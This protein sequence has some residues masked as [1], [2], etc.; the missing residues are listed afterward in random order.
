MKRFIY[1]FFIGMCIGGSAI[2]DTPQL[3]SNRKVK[4]SKPLALKRDIIKMS[5][6]KNFVRT[7][8]W[9]QD[10]VSQSYWNVWSDRSHNTTYN[11]PSESSGKF[12]ELTRI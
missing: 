2:A 8:K 10:E 9:G 6:L 12:K 5:D 7:G 1:T 4:V 11:G 3:P